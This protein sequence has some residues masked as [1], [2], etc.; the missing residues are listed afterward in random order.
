EADVPYIVFS[1]SAAVYGEPVEQIVFE[2]TTCTPINP[3]G[4]SK[5]ISEIALNNASHAWGLQAMSLRYFNVAGAV[6]PVLADT[7]VTNLMP[8]IRDVLSYGKLLSIFGDDYPTFDGTCIRDYI[9]VLDLVEAH[10][11]AL[12]GLG[13]KRQ[14]GLETFNVG[15]GQGSSV[16][17]IVQAFQKLPGVELKYEYTARR[18]GDPAALTANV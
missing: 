13:A 17:E 15:T 18:K 12:R 14:S 16:L 3:Y 8:A 6:N 7:T 5:L 11:A 4:E 9:H 10:L 2:D 1:S